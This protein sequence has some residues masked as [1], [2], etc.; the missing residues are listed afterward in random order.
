MRLSSQTVCKG[1]N[2]VLTNGVKDDGA[3]IMLPENCRNIAL[4]ILLLLYIDSRKMMLTRTDQR[5]ASQHL[6]H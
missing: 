1:G 2:D 6:L 3:G 4:Q 5:R